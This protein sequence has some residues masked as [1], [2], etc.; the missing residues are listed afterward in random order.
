[1]SDEGSA[2]GRA[3][4]NFVYSGG[5]G[6]SQQ[7]DRELPFR[8]LVLGDYT[9][10]AEPAP[11]AARRPLAVEKGR[12]DDVLAMLQ[13]QLV[14][15]RKDWGKDAA[16]REI[17][18]TF[19][20]LAD[21][22]P[23]GIAAEVPELQALL[24]HRSLLAYIEGRLSR[25][26]GFRTKDEEKVSSPEAQRALTSE[27]GIEAAL[28]D[29]LAGAPFL[30]I[31]EYP[32]VRRTVRQVLERVLAQG[33]VE[34]YLPQRM[35]DMMVALNNSV[36]RQLSDILHHPSFQQ[37]EAA[38]RGLA[39]L[40]DGIEPASGVLVDLLSVS[41]DELRADLEAASDVEASALGAILHRRVYERRPYCP[42]GVICANYDFDRGAA[43]LALL[44]RC[45]ALS[46][47]VNAPFISNASPSF[48]QETTFLSLSGSARP[49]SLFAGPTL[50]RWTAFRESE[51]AR[52][53]ALCLPRV[54]LRAPYG[55]RTG[56]TKSFVFYELVAGQHDRYLWGHASLA[57]V[58]RAAAS[59]AKYRWAPNLVGPADGLVKGLPPHEVEGA[60]QRRGAAEIAL[61]ERRAWELSEEG[62]VVL[63]GKPGTTYV[64]FC[65][66]VAKTTDRGLPKA[67]Q[68]EVD[69]QASAYLPFRFVTTRL[70]HYLQV[71]A[72]EHASADEGAALADVERTLRAW[73]DRYHQQAAFE[74]RGTVRGPPAIVEWCPL[75]GA[76]LEITADEREP[77]RCAFVLRVQLH[78]RWFGQPFTLSLGGTL[79][80]SQRRYGRPA[81]DA[82]VRDRE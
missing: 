10:R 67:S 81:S 11:L 43:D 21:F 9:L 56:P 57:L 73:L 7:T 70:A 33:G 16:D 28:D 29:I 76:E 41:K 52:N 60:D 15:R 55:A 6:D 63:R 66:S 36:R 8:I 26:P 24:A 79:E 40:I 2:V 13:P 35:V 64:D 3:R 68:A 18:L 61:T 75:H 34:T 12:L 39:F 69:D 71:L 78:R 19:R 82:H 23:E 5:S 22:D 17:S 1:M 27:A 54:L 44:E 14:L 25:I 30:S 20:S 74:C 45:A 50:D 42:Y 59:F 80:T 48:F 32:M 46:A 72:L 31:P 58:S 53:V 37:L 62:F 65:A 49:T 47:R 38:W 51:A 4:V 77:G